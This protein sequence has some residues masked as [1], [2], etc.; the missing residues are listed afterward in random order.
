MEA[1]SDAAWYM[2]VRHVVVK[3]IRSCTL[4]TTIIVPS[5]SL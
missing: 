5:L 2:E 1:M 3:K 4:D